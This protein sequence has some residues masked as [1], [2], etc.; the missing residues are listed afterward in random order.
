MFFEILCYQEVMNVNIFTYYIYCVCHAYYVVLQFIC[1]LL[2]CVSGK[3]SELKRRN[4][5]KMFEITPN[6]SGTVDSER[7]FTLLDFE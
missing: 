5:K 2:K 7:Q 4:R 3:S 1:L 6:C